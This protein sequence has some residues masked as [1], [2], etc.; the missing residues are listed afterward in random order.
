MTLNPVQLVSLHPVVDKVVGHL[1]ERHDTALVGAPGCGTTTLIPRIRENLS[2][3]N[4]EIYAFDLHSLTPMSKLMNNLN[5]IPTSVD[6]SEN[7]ILI[8]DHAA[9]LHPEDFRFLIENVQRQSAR[10]AGIILWAGQLDTRKIYDR[11]GVRIHTIP[12]SHISFPTLPRDEI[13][14]VYNAIAEAN[15]CR[16]GE[17]IMFLLLDFCG[18]DF[19]LLQGATE[20][21]YGDWSDKLYDESIWDR[22]T[23]WLANDAVVDEYRQCLN[24]LSEP[25]KQYLDLIRL[26]GKPPCP[27]AELLEEVDSA[28]RELCLQ[29]FLVQNHLPRF[30]QLRNLTIRFLI[31]E[32]LS[33]YA[34]FRRAS[35]ERVGQLLQD[36]ETMLRCT[37]F[38]TFNNLGEVE[39]IDL[40]KGKQGDSEF[41]PAQLNQ[42]LLDWANTRGGRELK[43]SLNALL[44]EHRK[45][46][47][48]NNSIWARV[49]KIMENEMPEEDEQA[50]PKHLQCIDYLTFAELGDIFLSLLEHVFPSV[51]ND[52]NAKNRLK[53]RWRDSISKVRRLR[54]Q[55][56]HLRNI[57]FQDMED[58]VG[59]ID[60]MRK[61][62][63]N[64]GGWKQ[65]S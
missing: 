47:K 60:G 56:A 35:N 11:F 59:T 6:G 62:L 10:I 32:P 39:V 14:A 24:R 12:K 26:G 43:E 44:I 30:Y 8:I 18:N 20:Y 36:V 15:D 57:E 50:I 48:L 64:Y 58:L 53:G 45:T 37:V 3:H 19:S 54:N 2:E 1:R 31:H 46:F 22:V 27:R 63:I 40:L 29:G 33:P 65:V 28:L 7:R 49:N 25:C 55:V 5:S 16:W 41:M 38:S 51:V 13:L 23:E 61:D 4:Y 52:V 9:S 17:A 21:L 34:L 42:A